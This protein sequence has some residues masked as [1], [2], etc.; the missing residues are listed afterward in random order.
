M[1]YA[2]FPFIALAIAFIAI[3]ATGQRTFIYVGI[4]FLGD[5][6]DEQDPKPQL[7]GPNEF[8]KSSCF[9]L[10]LDQ[11]E[12]TGTVSLGICGRNAKL[13]LNVVLA[14]L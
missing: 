11:L 4:V 1:R 7:S 5:S 2:P 14:H 3:G 8:L 12:E 6:P 9:H 10:R 13:V